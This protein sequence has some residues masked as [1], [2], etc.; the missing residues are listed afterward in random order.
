M[1][2]SPIHTYRALLREC[3]YIFDH[4]ARNYFKDYVTSSYRRYLPK[5]ERFAFCNPTVEA[6]TREL[7]L[8]HRARKL[9]S[10]L[11]RANNGDL[12]PFETVLKLTYAR[13]GKRRREIVSALIAE[14]QNEEVR[15]PYTDVS[16]SKDKDDH[17]FGPAWK[18]SATL[19]ALLRSQGRQQAYLTFIGAKVSPRG[20]DVPK[21]N[22]WAKPFPESRARNKR[23][24][25]YAKNADLI[26]PPLP[27]SE[28]DAIKAI[29]S[30][31]RDPEAQRK[32]RPLACV[33]VFVEL[34]L[35]RASERLLVNYVSAGRRRN[36]C[37][38]VSKPHQVTTRFVKRRMVKLLK[39]IP[40]PL[41]HKIA[42]STDPVYKWEGRTDVH[43]QVKD[44]DSVQAQKLFR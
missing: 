16:D 35:S 7:P 2:R 39:H 8:L 23:R 34:D 25:W 32:R 21:E 6:A 26:F 38:V 27:S 12:R 4:N 29:A 40:Q 36:S 17:K 13:S 22:I 19:T 3:T 44:A 42:G 41:E 11:R 43:F 20:P 31:S 30:G 1:S 5:D 37:P 24:Q 14:A 15:D 10:L 28:T 9:H 18:P 33:N